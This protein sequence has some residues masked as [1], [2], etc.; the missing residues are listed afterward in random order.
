MAAV[1]AV[2]EGTFDETPVTPVDPIDPVASDIVLRGNSI[3]LNGQ[4]DVNF[5]LDIPDELF[6]A[7]I[8]A[9]LDG[10]RV[11]FIEGQYGTMVSKKLPAKEMNTKVTLKLY[12]ADGTPLTFKNGSA[13]VTEHRYSVQDYLTYVISNPATYGDELVN[14]CKAMSDY[15]A[16][17]QRELGFDVENAKDIYLADEIANVTCEGYGYGFTP[18]TENISF[19][20][21]S[22]V[23]ESETAIRVYFALSGEGFTA[24][25]DGEPAA[26]QTNERG[27]FVEIANIS[28]KNLGDPHT[29]AITNGS[30]TVTITNCSAYSYVQSVLGYAGA[31]DSLKLAAKALKLYGDLAAE[32]FNK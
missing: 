2:N 19:L 6:D 28:A 8:Y 26:I 7:E 30:E 13:D 9:T 29:I 20:G 1:E 18:N 25:V 5:Y 14:L 12:A 11:D 27:A 4:I 16:Y 24:T 17:T 15:G 21:A 3:S 32:Y 31:S 22:V 23:T 10:K